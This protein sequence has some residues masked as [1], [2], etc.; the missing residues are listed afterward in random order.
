M[1]EYRPW[2]F[3]SLSL[4]AH[5]LHPFPL[6]LMTRGCFRAA[7]MSAARASG[8]PTA[9]RHEILLNTSGPS[10]GVDVVRLASRSEAH[11]RRLTVV[12]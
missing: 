5:R 9:G 8:E 2:V 4:D 7:H 12:R 1:S 11:A 3:A 6:K 10:A